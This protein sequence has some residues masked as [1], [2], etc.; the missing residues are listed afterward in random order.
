[1][2]STKKK[3]LEEKWKRAVADYRNLERRVRAER[4]EFVRFANAALLLRILPVVDDLERAADAEADKGIKNI[5]DKFKRVLELEGVV[6]IKALG[7]EFGSE[8]MEAVEAESGGGEAKNSSGR[9][10]EVLEKGY[11]LGEK[12]IRPAKVRVG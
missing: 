10:T 4:G 3:G 12:V 6:E 1:M 11:K 7:E 5:L 9:V 8:L 2:S